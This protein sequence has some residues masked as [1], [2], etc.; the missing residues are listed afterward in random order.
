MI[1]QIESKA[2]KARRARCRSELSGRSDQSVRTASHRPLRT[3]IAMC[4]ARQ[5]VRMGVGPE[6]WLSARVPT[7][8]GI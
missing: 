3:T 2:P 8:E 5:D 6:A 4:E 1:L 7:K